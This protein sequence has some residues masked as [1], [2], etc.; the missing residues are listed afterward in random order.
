VT[1]YFTVIRKVACT[2]SAHPVW[3]IDIERKGGDLLARGI[4]EAVT[5][6]S[7][8]F[9]GGRE[10]GDGSAQREA[11]LLFVFYTVIGE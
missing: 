3:R 7:G 10:A 5:V 1:P 2:L 4:R 9:H 6:R 8:W 11:L